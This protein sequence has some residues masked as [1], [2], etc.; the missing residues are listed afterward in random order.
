MA[1]V[2]TCP[3]KA[4]TMKNN[5]YGFIYPEIDEITCIDCGACK[6]ICAFTKENSHITSDCLVCVNK[7]YEKN[8][9]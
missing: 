9:I 7:D 8:L 2:V 3:K 5:Q 6:N 1:C 4:I